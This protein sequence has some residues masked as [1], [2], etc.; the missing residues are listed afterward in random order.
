M[1]AKIEFGCGMR[2]TPGYLHHDRTMHSTHVDWAYDLNETPWPLAEEMLDEILALDVMEHLKIDVNVWL[3]ECH[4]IL[5]PEGVLHIRVPSWDNPVSYRDTTHRRVFH[6]ESF[7]FWDVGHPLW[8]NYGKFY[9][10]ESGRWWKVASVKRVNP[11]SR[12]GIG[13]LEFILWKR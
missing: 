7:Y 11:D 1:L 5:K 8:E 9:Y 10:A 6:E 2:P 12:Y 3:D 13:D 4:R